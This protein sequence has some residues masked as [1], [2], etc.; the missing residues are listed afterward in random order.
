MPP[1]IVSPTMTVPKY[2]PKLAKV[3]ATSFISRI[4]PATKNMT[5]IGAKLITQVVIFIMT[6]KIAFHRFFNVIA[7]IIV[8][9]GLTVVKLAKKS[10]IG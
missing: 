8:V 5:P 4:C 1:W 6:C 9:Y 3:L 2:H 10:K 7:T